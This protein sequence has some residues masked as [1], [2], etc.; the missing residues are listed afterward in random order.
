M[1]KILSEGFGLGI[2]TG[3]TCLTTC[4]PIYI[5]FLLSEK[6]SIW[7]SFLKVMEISAGRFIAYTAF[8]AIAGLAGSTISNINRD[9]FTSIAYILISTYLLVT[10]YRTHKRSKMCVIPKF[11][12]FTQNA[13][14]LG[15]ITGINF[16]PSFLLAISEAIG[17]GGAFGG[18]LLFIGFFGGTTIYLIPLIFVGG[19]SK[20]KKMQGI[21]K[22]LSVII[23]V[24]FLFVGIQTAYHY[25]SHRNIKNDVTAQYLDV[26]APNQELTVVCDK[27]DLKYFM[28]LRDSLKNNYHGKVDFVLS[29]NE[30]VSGKVIFIQ[31]K[32]WLQ[33]KAKYQNFNKI[34]VDD[35]Y[36]IS[37]IISH[38][39]SHVFKTS[40]PLQWKFENK[41]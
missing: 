23:G 25:I 26:F 30:K 12:K 33:N 21:A 41:K 10:A 29:S 3:L 35:N 7:N 34:I 16:C 14:L 1:L 19:I 32:L 20:I 9:I 6:R 24:Y 37:T 15:F 39:K 38:L 11:S 36:D 8:G 28:A 40:K 22:Y 4:S 17:L 27:T 31:K 5:P 13:F 18:A 2:A